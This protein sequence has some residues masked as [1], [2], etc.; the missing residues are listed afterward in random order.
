MIPAGGMYAVDVVLDDGLLVLLLHHPHDGVE[1]ALSILPLPLLDGMGHPLPARYE[2]V[3]SVHLLPVLETGT[4]R[5][6]HQLLP[7]PQGR[8]EGRAAFRQSPFQVLAQYASDGEG[9]APQTVFQQRPAEG[10]ARP[11]PR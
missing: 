4:I 1:D 5:R 10:R 6:L 8:A 11:I 9:T 2:L 7:E 3:E